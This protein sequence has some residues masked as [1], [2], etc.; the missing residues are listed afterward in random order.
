[1]TTSGTCS[2]QGRSR[3]A[4]GLDDIVDLNKHDERI[5]KKD[6]RCDVGCE[7]A[8]GIHG[9]NRLDDMAQLTVGRIAAMLASRL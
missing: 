2:L 3:K 7:V 8:G 1:M 4:T 5:I 9:S 6:A